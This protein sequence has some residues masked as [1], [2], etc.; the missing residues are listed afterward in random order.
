MNMNNSQ[1]AE[2]LRVDS[3]TVSVTKYRLKQKLGLNK[4]EELDDFIRK[5]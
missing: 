4:D 5:L 1:I 2:T 3:K